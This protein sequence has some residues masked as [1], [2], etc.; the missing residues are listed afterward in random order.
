MFGVTDFQTLPA[1][2]LE[3]IALYVPNTESTFA[4][5]VYDPGHCDGRPDKTYLPLLGVNRTL[6]I[7]TAPLFYKSASKAVGI[8]E[9]TQYNQFKPSDT[10]S[11]NDIVKIGTQ[12]YIKQLRITI[13]IYALEECILDDSNHVE[14]VVIP[15]I[16]ACGNFPA[17]R[18]LY[19]SIYNNNC[20]RYEAAARRRHA[21]NFP[22]DP[23]N[24]DPAVIDMPKELDAIRRAIFDIIPCVR[25]VIA[26]ND[27]MGSYTPSEHDKMRSREAV[28]FMEN[29]VSHLALGHISLIKVTVSKRLLANMSGSGM[30]LRSIT[31]SHNKGSQ[32]HVELVRRNW[33]RLERL[34]IDHPTA[35]A[36]VKMTWCDGGS[37]TLVYPQLKYLCINICSGNRSAS[38]RQPNK[39]PFPAL[40]TL[41]CHGQFPFATPVVLTEGS[42]HIRR[43]DIDLDNELMEEYGNE[44]FA[45]KSFQALES[46]SLGWWARGPIRVSQSQM[47]F[48]RALSIG[49]NTRVAHI[50]CFDTDWLDNTTFQGMQAL[51][52]LQLLDME[53]TYITPSQAL[54]IFNACPLLQKAYISLREETSR[55]GEIRMPS[56]TELIEFQETHKG[57]TSMIQSLGIYSTI[58]SRSRRAAEYVVML[59]NV[60]P[61]LKRVCISSFVRVIPNKYFPDSTSA[62]KLF[63]AISQTRKRKFYK[64]N[65]KVHSVNVAI[66]NCW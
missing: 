25:R 47:I 11:L 63:D 24:K 13:D 56:E 12:S 30:A 50:R 64:N 1:H 16:K 5:T 58:F 51:S 14:N 21:L 55:R 62:R 17:V 66:D 4:M 23:K 3:R 2:I 15:S 45:E 44:L 65:P 29:S 48:T 22:D 38:Y 60:L 57:C 46:V 26:N 28:D 7:V 35:H 42:K 36:V 20:L 10:L 40:T 37:G 34:H 54:T 49:V 19:L 41:I 61:C 52:T 33:M 31:L 27:I 6:R 39:D 32:Q 59:A 8:V 53:L 9:R 18:T 43:L